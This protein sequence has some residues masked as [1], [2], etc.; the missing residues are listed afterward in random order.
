MDSPT[1][2][3]LN[4]DKLGH[5][6]STMDTD[7]ATYTKPGHSSTASM[8]NPSIG[9]LSPIYV[10]EHALT[11]Q[12]ESI[13]VSHARAAT[14]DSAPHMP[15]AV[16]SRNLTNEPV[17]GLSGDLPALN[18][19][20]PPPAPPE[21]DKATALPPPTARK[22][23]S[24]FAWFSRATARKATSPTRAPESGTRRNTASS[25]TTLA[26]APDNLDDGPLK[27]PGRG[28]GNS[29]KDRFQQL[30][31][32]EE[33]GT[34]STVDE[35]AVVSSG[36]MQSPTRE[37]GRT[38]SP[39]HT[40][41]STSFSGLP[42]PT[43]VKL[44]PG[45]AS[46][47]SVGPSEDNS[48]VNWDL[49]Q[50]VVYEGPTAV[51]RTSGEELNRAIA[52]G[53]PQPIRGVVWQVLAES[54]NEDLEVMYRE[55]VAR[56]TDKEIIRPAPA[57]RSISGGLVNGSEKDSV[58]SSASSIRSDVSGPATS[59]MPVSPG[60]T[61]SEDTAFQLEKRRKSDKDQA[62]ALQKL[63]K[64][65]RRDLGART[66]YSKY[67]AS[68]G[69]QE[70]LFGICKAYALFDEPVGYAQGMNFIAMP[71]LF[72]MP[73]EEAFT[74]FVRLMS[75]YNLRSLFTAEMP[76]LHLRL[77]QFE[78]LLE[79]YEPALYCHLHRRGVSPNLY[80]TQWFLTLF[81]YR[82]PLQLVLR[83]YDLI[84]SEGL[85]A[86]LKFGIVLMQKNAKTL[87]EMKDMAQLSNFLKERIFDVYIN[88]SPSASSILESGFFGSAGGVDKEIY[89]ADDLVRDACA[90][91]IAPETLAT[92][93][94]EFEE[95]QR[96]EKDREF[97]LETLRTN[98]TSLSTRV[99]NLEERAQQH[100][101]EHVGIASELVRTKVDNEA[102]EDANESLKMQVAE[103]RKV[104][105]VQP[106]E[107][108]ERL[109]EEM[110]RIMKRNIEVQNENRALEE[111]VQETEHELVNTKMMF[112]EV[113]CDCS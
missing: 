59:S 92:Y 107:V 73:E 50:S 25:L 23:S 82:F 63:E 87:L 108:E 71:L 8:D 45:T 51:A 31:F 97:E 48:A 88:K 68:A 75:K 55:L 54:K 24:P 72:N 109:R 38:L 49:W 43:S 110:E 99:R 105:E 27:S 13:E 9:P 83:V 58:A 35:D 91:T 79:D 76:G 95:Q 12:G 66:S 61:T 65:I 6:P 102:L 90:F 2:G 81:A 103:L 36:G 101:T 14:L 1:A 69:L 96:T 3:A 32:Q 5:S 70:G 112:A 10:G 47:M 17:K 64:A 30:R 11:C 34:M 53:I 37:E 77:Y 56:G 113:S 93:T 4:T 100:D 42:S 57:S 78:R 104:V 22:V 7:A 15:P 19:P 39:R 67:L 98:N 41:R 16:P 89:H 62:A 80:A 94:T 106:A 46:G 111:T 33:A 86:I 74:L 18:Y 20:P 85:G 60:F 52:S 26:S 28:R 84:F 29:L 21:K 40:A 44:P